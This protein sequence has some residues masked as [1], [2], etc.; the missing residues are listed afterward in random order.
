M[1]D[2]LLTI[3]SNA[4]DITN[5]IILTHNIDFVFVQSVVIPALR[6][7]GSPSLTIF[8]DADCATHTYQYQYRVLSDLGRR[9]RV[10]P[11]AMKTGFRFHP[12]AVLLSG[13]KRATLLVGSGNLTYGGWKENGEIWFCYDSDTDG[14]GSFAGFR[15]YLD[16]IVNLCAEPR[17][18]VASDV[19]ESF[20]SNTRTWAATMD[21]PGVLLGR[22]GR[23][24]S[25]LEQIRR[26]S[27]SGD[28]E[29][30]YVCAPYFDEDA[31]AMRSLA[32]ALGAA[33]STILVQSKRTNLLASAATSLGNQFTFREVR[34]EHKERNASDV[35]ARTRKAWIHAKFY[36]VRRGEEVDIFA[37]SANCSRAALTIPGSAGNAELMIHATLSWV[38]FKKAFL[39]ELVVDDISPEF[40]TGPNPK[41]SIESQESYI[42]VRAARMDF[43]R[44]RVSYDADTGVEIT[45]C[46]ADNTV[47]SP[48]ELGTASV[49]F[50]SAQQPQ[51][52]VLV[53]SKGE[54]NI[55]SRPHWI[56]NENALR[57]SARGR[58]LANSI[59]SRVRDSTWGIGAWSEVLSEFL[60]H[61]EYMPKAL[62]PRTTGARD[63]DE[64]TGP[65]A[66]VWDDVFSDSYGLPGVSGFMTNLPTNRDTRI[67]SLRSMLLRWYGID[68]SEP[69]SDFTSHDHDSDSRGT[70]SAYDD[71]DSPDRITALPQPPG[72]QTLPPVAD[73]DR[74]RGLKIITEVANR[75]AEPVFLSERP[76]ELLAADLKVAAILFRT[77]LT[78]AWI[79]E[80]EFLNA[81]LS[82][83][84]PL[85]FDAGRKENIGWLEQR[86]L[87]ASTQHEFVG[88]IQSVELAAA[89]GCWALS[90]TTIVNSP[91][92][93]L[94]CL[95]SILGVARLP[96]LWQSGG[97]ERI[98]K[99][100]LKGLECTSSVDDLNWKVIKHRWLTLIRRGRALDYLEKAISSVGL[101]ELRNRI[102]Q[103]QIATGELLWQGPR[104]GYCVAASNC[105]RNPG[106]KDNVDVLMLQRRM[107]KKKFK[108][109]FL[110]PVAGLLEDGVLRT[111]MMPPHVRKELRAMLNELRVGLATK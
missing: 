79:T 109:S 43:G 50:Q 97:N 106:R 88:A 98:A 15:N 99:E 5:A 39:D 81:T 41:M 19:E 66:F 90:T 63:K 89:L 20:D 84:L 22:A 53:G 75:L 96:W 23:G 29:H 57:T 59:H 1:R 83:W 42:R 73:T 28:A 52:I 13:P 105:S 64:G 40:A 11:V 46:E 34:F 49:T 70:G 108:V 7:C 25:M 95:A 45:H 48:V 69:D 26:V 37:G 8:A 82:I 27:R 21:P 44:I 35:T 30:L 58:T 100:I 86:I 18:A 33:F 17:N 65:V 60:K 6:K 38:E 77:G 36:A 16:E 32:Q 24:D 92:H 101:A 72:R 76:P 103:L 56:D 31:D 102:A 93:S 3:I 104:L 71:S 107:A 74:K 51:R 91:E 54:K 62:H 78:E 47:L 111:K 80:Q 12:K 94:F 110:I 87:T 2:D 68:Q 4:K 61:I 55:H 10:V 85:F 14:T 9:Y 67:G